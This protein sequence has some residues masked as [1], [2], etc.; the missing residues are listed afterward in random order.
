VFVLLKIPYSFGILPYI[1]DWRPERNVKVVAEEIMRLTA[2][3]PLRTQND[4]STGLA[5]AAYLDAWQQ[6]RE[7]VRWYHEQDQEK[8]VFIMA[9]A[10][11]PRLGKLI[12]T[13]RLRG[14]TVYLY[15]QPEQ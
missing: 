12:K 6:D 10:E 5:I 2:E 15:W 4:V 7:P 1:K 3:A 9:E 14:D 11:T 8:G 13:W